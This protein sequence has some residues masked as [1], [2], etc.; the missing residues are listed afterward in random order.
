M[1]RGFGLARIALAAA[2]LAPL[3]LIAG[4]RAAQAQGAPMGMPMGMPMGGPPAAPPAICNSFHALSQ[5]AQKRGSAVSNAIKAKVDRKQICTLMNTFI[6]AET[7]VVKFLIDNRATCGVP[8]EAITASK[9]GHERS[10]KFRT[11]VCS[12]D[13]GGQRRPLSLS[14]AIK[15]SPLDTSKNTK[16]GVGSA[17]TFDT[18]TGNPLAR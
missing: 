3:A 8:P 1:Q 13:G 6:T 14:D 5:E 18:L 17:G 9:A 2:V 11:E 16:A 7:T 15:S 10:L 12:E 4:P